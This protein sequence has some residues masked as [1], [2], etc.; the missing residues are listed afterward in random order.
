MDLILM[1]HKTRKYILMNIVFFVVFFGIYYILDINANGSYAGFSNDFG[2]TTVVVHLLMNL[3]LAVG[4][5]VIFTWSYISMQVHKRD[6]RWSNV[7]VLGVFIGFLT[8]GCTPCVVALLSIFG[9]TFVPMV[10]PNA[11]L[12]W[13][14][15]VLLLIVFSGWMTIYSVNKGCKVENKA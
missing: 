6:S 2:T 12:L 13:K 4:S 14:V 3:L 5:S 9:V 15:L 11:N 1:M 8:F 10:L 7:P